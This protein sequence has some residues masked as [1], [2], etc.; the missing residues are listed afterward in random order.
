M[1]LINEGSVMGAITN[2]RLVWIGGRF[3]GGKTSLAFAI[4]AYYGDFGYR[5]ITNC[6]SVWAD[7]PQKVKLLEQGNDAGHLK[8]VILLDEGGIEFETNKQVSEI[9][10]YAAKMDMIFL[11]PS[12]NP[13]ARKFQ[14]LSIQPVWN[15]KPVGIPYIHYKWTVQLG[16]FKEEGSFG[17]WFPQE[18]FVVYSRQDPS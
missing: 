15:L 12:F 2:Y 8:A 7:D 5:I 6:Q 17:W 3:S 9:S 10:A 4:A 14:V 16:S 1:G 11:V 18:V 13:P